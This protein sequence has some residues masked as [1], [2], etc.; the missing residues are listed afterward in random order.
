MTRIQF[1]YHLPRRVL[2]QQMKNPKQD[3]RVLSHS[4]HPNHCLPSHPT[5]ITLHSRQ[6]LGSK[7][8]PYCPHQT[9]AWAVPFIPSQLHCV[10]GEWEPRQAPSAGP[11]PWGDRRHG[12]MMSTPFLPLTTAL[13]S[14]HHSAEAPVP[15][16]PSLLLR[17]TT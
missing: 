15:A 12:C 16:C 13:N 5:P 4:P 7:V 11:H 8:T 17:V 10:P 1:S 2:S 14:R 3:D 6:T 9:G